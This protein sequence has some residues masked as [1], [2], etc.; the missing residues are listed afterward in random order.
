MPDQLYLRCP[1]TFIWDTCFTSSQMNPFTLWAAKGLWVGPGISDS[2]LFIFIFQ[3]Y[4]DRSFMLMYAPWRCLD[5]DVEGTKK[6]NGQRPHTSDFFLPTWLASPTSPA[7]PTITHPPPWSNWP[8][9]AVGQHLWLTPYQIRN[10]FDYYV[11]PLL[12]SAH[13]PKSIVSICIAIDDID[14]NS[15]L[16]LKVAELN[17]KVFK[18]CFKTFNIEIY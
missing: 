3:S 13:I 2:W 17:I 5:C 15:L 7:P 1:F 8:L 10:T 4:M 14:L 12:R 9:K 18:F 11:T 16:N 6:S